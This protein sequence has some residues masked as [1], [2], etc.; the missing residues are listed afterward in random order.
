MLAD[1]DYLFKTD[2]KLF[3]WQLPP[4]KRWSTRKNGEMRIVPYENG[5]KSQ[6]VFMP[7]N[8]ESLTMNYCADISE[9]RGGMRAIIHSALA[10]KMHDRDPKAILFGKAASRSYSNSRGQ[11]I[12]TVWCVRFSKRWAANNFSFLLN[13]L[14]ELNGNVRAYLNAQNHVDLFDF[15]VDD[16]GTEDGSDEVDDGEDLLD[17]NESVY[18][19]PDEPAYYDV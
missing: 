10:V 9:Q 18:R 2:A 14:V 8:S 11:A 1:D 4:V 7:S 19:Y 16:E 6:L 3:F 12:R 15:Q 17:D 5:T 13:R